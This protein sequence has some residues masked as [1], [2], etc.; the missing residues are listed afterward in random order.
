MSVLPCFQPAESSHIWCLHPLEGEEIDLVNLAAARRKSQH[1]SLGTSLSFEG[2]RI[3]T[4]ACPYL[5]WFPCSFCIPSLNLFFCRLPFT[6]P[7]FSVAL[8]CLLV[9]QSHP[10]LKLSVSFPISPPSFFVLLSLLFS[11]LYR[12]RQIVCPWVTALPVSASYGSTRLIDFQS[13]LVSAKEAIGC[14]RLRSGSTSFCA[15]AW[16]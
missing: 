1:L 4:P 5:P 11:L 8:H 3:E 2:R 12:L 7:P 16:F 14:S 9:R 10:C 13:L 6:F 15:A